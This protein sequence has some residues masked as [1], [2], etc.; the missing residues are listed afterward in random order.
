MFQKQL[1]IKKK[2]FPVLPVQSYSILSF[3]RLE[4]KPKAFKIAWVLGFR[5]NRKQ[6]GQSL[7]GFVL[8]LKPF[9]FLASTPGLL[10][11]QTIC[12]SSDCRSYGFSYSHLRTF[13]MPRGEAPWSRS[14]LLAGSFHGGSQT[15]PDTRQESEPLRSP[16]G[17][18]VRQQ[19]M[20]RNTKYHIRSCLKKGRFRKEHYP[21]GQSLPLAPADLQVLSGCPDRERA[22]ADRCYKT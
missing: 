13:L 20:G 5:N 10:G 6:Q 7:F 22:Q 11:S 9:V 18:W 1:F 14:A 17:G 8:L 19:R 2:H 21:P 16:A 15:L 3:P 4:Q 12:L